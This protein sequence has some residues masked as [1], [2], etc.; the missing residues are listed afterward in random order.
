MKDSV[1]FFRYIPMALERNNHPDNENGLAPVAVNF[2][3][4]ADEDPSTVKG[5][6]CV[7]GKVD[8][9]IFGYI[10][11]AGSGITAT[12]GT[13]TY[14]ILSA[15]GDNKGMCYSN[16]EQT[17]KTSPGSSGEIGNC[18]YKTYVY[19]RVLPDIEKVR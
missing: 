6:L 4:Y 5:D 1:G 17:E 8:A 9:S 2:F 14:E 11:P 13:A 3:E 15:A 19:S 7:S 18:T 12:S 10:P 16:V